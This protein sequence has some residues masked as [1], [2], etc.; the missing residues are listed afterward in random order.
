MVTRICAAAAVVF[1]AGP[2][3]AWGFGGIKGNGQ[4]IT[5]AREVPPFERVSMRGAIDAVVKVGPAQSVSITIDSNLITHVRT[6]VEGDRLVIDTDE[7]LSWDGIAR[8]EITVP[9][10]RA[11]GVSGSSDATIEGGKGEELQLS[12]SGSGDIRWRGVATALE[13]A[14]SGSGDV[15]LAGEADAL[16]AS[17]SG[18]GD[19]RGQDFTVRDAD[20]RTSGSGDVTIRLSGGTLRAKTSGSGDVTWSGE[21]TVAEARTSGSGEVRRR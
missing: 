14:T 13:V 8:A 7:N 9:R 5:E 15:T 19:V 3:Q 18:S 12:T 6:R 16:E 17:T 11:F 21:G 4:K 1:L 2:A 20:I 10:L